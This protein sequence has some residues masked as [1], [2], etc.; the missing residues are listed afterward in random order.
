MG[1]YLNSLDVAVA[2]LTQEKNTTKTSKH[3]LLDLQDQNTLTVL[4]APFWIQQEK[5]TFERET[6]QKLYFSKIL[7]E[8]LL[9]RQ[10]KQKVS[11]IMFTGEN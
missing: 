11:V 1:P 8:Q 6:L 10:K 5:P 4:C 9:F 2:Y 3:T 7:T